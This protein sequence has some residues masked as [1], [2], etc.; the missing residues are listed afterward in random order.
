MLRFPLYL[1][2]ALRAGFE[3]AADDDRAVRSGSAQPGARLALAE[4]DRNPGWPGLTG[5]LVGSLDT[6]SDS[7]KGSGYERISEPG[8]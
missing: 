3:A 4:V 1:F 7:R 6:K 8:C 2:I 5:L